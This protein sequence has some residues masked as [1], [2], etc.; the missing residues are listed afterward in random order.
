[1]GIGSGFLPVLKILIIFFQ[2]SFNVTVDTYR[3]KKD[4]VNTTQAGVVESLSSSKGNITENKGN[5]TK[6]QFV[7]QDI[8]T[9]RR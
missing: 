3:D 2:F 6:P 1:M 9:E 4:V 5:K 7:F 8:P